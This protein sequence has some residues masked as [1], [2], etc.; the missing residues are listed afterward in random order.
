MGREVSGFVR[1]VS[2]LSMERVDEVS[3]E[4]E[5]IP[6]PEDEFEV[7]HSE[8]H[9]MWWPEVSMQSSWNQRPQGP[10]HMTSWFEGTEVVP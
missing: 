9:P 7:Q 4:R 3:A 2:K 8:H 5:P 6:W 10:P 1:L